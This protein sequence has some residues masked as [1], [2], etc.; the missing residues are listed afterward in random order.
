MTTPLSY[1]LKTAAEAT[2]LTTTTLS[3]AIKSTRLKA[4]KSGLTPDGEPAGSY[5]IL[6]ADLMAWLEGLTAA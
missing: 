5:V 2:G 1:T 3:R 6:H 4:R